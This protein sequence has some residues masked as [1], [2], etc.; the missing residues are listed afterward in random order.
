[1]VVLGTLVI[2]RVTDL[3]TDQVIFEVISAFGTVGL[4]TGITAELPPVGQLVLVRADVRG[5]GRH[6]HAGHVARAGRAAHGLALSRG[7]SD[8]WVSCSPSSSP[9][10]KG[11]SVV[12]I[13]LGRFGGA[14]A[15][16]LIS[17]G[18][19]VM[20][21]DRDAEPVQAWADRLT[22]AVQADATNVMVMR[23]LGVADFRMP[24]S[25]SATTW[26]PA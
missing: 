7:A 26:P 1:M 22:H 9:S 10:A 16:S 18:H 21:I 19:D 15:Q 13:G 6:H 2:L 8:C 24:S 17:L 25:A 14:V 4:S 5:P 12:V 11:D 3:P 23:Q 20:G